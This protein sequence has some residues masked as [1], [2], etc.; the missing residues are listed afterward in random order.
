MKEITFKKLEKEDILALTKIMKRAFDKDI[1]IHLNEPSGGPEGY[2]D[3]TF[4]TKWGLHK[5]ATSFEIFL[6]DLLIGAVILWIHDSGY[7]FLGNIFIDEAYEGK[8]YGTLVW[9]KI[10]KM[11]PK[12]IMWKTETPI[13]SHRNHVFYINKCGFHVVKITNHTNIKEGSYIFEKQ[14]K[15]S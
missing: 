8:G 6:D 13:Y 2:D 9:E 10:E 7:N 15:N 11:Y 4:L 14:M 3:G 1:Q 12:T 5:N